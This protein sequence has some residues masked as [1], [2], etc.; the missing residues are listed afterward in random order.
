[1]I[2]RALA[3]VLTVVA[4]TAVPTERA[5]EEAALAVEMA[6]ANPWTHLELQNDPRDFTFAIVS[7]LTGGY[8]EDV[9]PAAVER[10][11]LLR[12]EF[13]L[14]VGDLIEGYTE[15]R[16]QLARE[17]N[18]FD[19]MLEPLLAP[20]FYVPGNHDYSNEVMAEVW[21]ERLGRD[22]Y[23]F[24]YQNVLFLALNTEHVPVELPPGV[25]ELLA[26][27]QAL[28]DTDPERA[29]ALAAQLT[30]GIDWE[31]DV[32]A[33]FG[34]EQVAYFEDVI[35]AHPDVRWTLLFMHKPVWQGAGSDDL[36]RMEAALGDRPFTVF[37]GHV[38]NYRRFEVGGRVHIRLGTTGGHWV[39][40]GSEGNYDHVVLVT[41]TDDGP[42][43][44]NLLLDGILD[45]HGRIDPDAHQWRARAK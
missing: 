34:E 4:C 19:G 32:Q 45:E 5:S 8:R 43:I 42:S 21:R 10:L 35:A 16:V 24:V 20:F 22:Y 26:Q 3:L 13:V 23:H 6:D 36:R 7:D 17:W 29:A 27:I 11:N 18:A 41:M 39:V 37:A 14:S 30:A 15:E 2:S 38:H 28:R 9:F 33:S 1:M 40:G 44:A 31:G 12:P 25:A